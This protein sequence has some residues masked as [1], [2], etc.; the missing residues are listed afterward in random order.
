MVDAACLEFLIM[1]AVRGKDA[2]CGPKW[3]RPDQVLPPISGIQAPVQV[4][5]KTCRLQTRSQI[6]KQFLNA[7]CAWRIPS[8]RVDVEQQVRSVV[9]A[10]LINIV[11]RCHVFLELEHSVAKMI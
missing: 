10:R 6:T 2:V 4:E 7:L 5:M 11:G 9:N 3:V 1:P 8:V